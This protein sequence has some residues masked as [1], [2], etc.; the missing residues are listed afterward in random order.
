MRTPLKILPKEKGIS[1]LFLIMALLLLTT[2]I[3]VLSYLMPMKHKG[4]LFSIHS[5]QALALAQ[6]GLEYG[7]RYSADQGWRTPLDLL[8]LNNPGVSQRNLGN[9]RF[10]IQYD[11][12][13]DQL[14]S[15]GEINNS[16][17]RRVVTLTN[18]S[19]FLRLVFAPT[20]PLPCWA[21]GTRQ[22]RFFIQNVQ[23]ENVTLTAFAASWTQSPPTR[24]ITRLDME[25]GQ[26]FSGHYNNG[27]PAVIFNSGGGQQI[28]LPGAVIP[29]IIEWNDQV[30]NG[31]NILITFY[32][33]EGKS[34][35]FNLDA[36]GDG[37]PSC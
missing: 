26:K 35:A 33:P 18:F 17:V 11:H 25:G 14:T 12:S 28:I 24:W 19:S 34:Y 32:T 1:L 30:L 23:N 8:R 27:Q 13:A 20:S 3:Y 21:L 22:V 7:L 31:A 16:F 10:L 37:L 4:L 9:G 5:L 29:V 2:L 6:S 15:T 36:N